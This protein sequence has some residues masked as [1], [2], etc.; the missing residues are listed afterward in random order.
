MVSRGGPNTLLQAIS[1]ECS[2]LVAENHNLKNELGDQMGTIAYLR[3]E[4]GE[5]QDLLNETINE[6]LNQAPECWDGDAFAGQIA[7][8]FVNS[9]VNG[10]TSM[11]G[12]RDD[13]TCFD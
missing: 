3:K 2:R 10:T 5:A 8:D 6:I 7:I 13:C 9:L 11:P 1:E 4:L 12:H